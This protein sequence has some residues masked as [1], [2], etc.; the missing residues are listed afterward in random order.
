M[1]LHVKCI[2]LLG[3]N[4]TCRPSYNM[5][6]KYHIQITFIG[7]VCPTNIHVVYI[8]TNKNYVI[9]HGSVENHD[10]DS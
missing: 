7:K 5:Y 10:N 2:Y 6:K 8:C 1:H 4:V 9:G 3:V